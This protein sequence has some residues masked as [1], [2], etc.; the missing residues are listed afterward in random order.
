MD[1]FDAAFGEGFLK[2]PIGESVA[3]VPAHSDQDDLWWESETGECWLGRLIRVSVSVV[4]HGDSLGR[5]R[6]GREL[7]GGQAKW[8]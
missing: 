3:Q 8:R 1:C 5:Q 7:R 2:I 4:L 6:P